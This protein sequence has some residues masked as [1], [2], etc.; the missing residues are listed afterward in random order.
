MK[1]CEYGTWDLIHKNSISFVTNKW[2]QQA[3]VFVPDQPLQ[4][5]LM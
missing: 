2:V 4:Q 5:I 1:C 3:K